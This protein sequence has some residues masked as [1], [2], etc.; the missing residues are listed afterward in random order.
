VLLNIK[1]TI[2]CFTETVKLLTELKNQEESPLQEIHY[3]HE[4]SSLGFYSIERNPDISRNISLDTVF[5][6]CLCCHP[7]LTNFPTIILVQNYDSGEK[8]GNLSVRIYP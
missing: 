5:V 6:W 2:G 3:Y 8:H 1:N 4:L 7:T